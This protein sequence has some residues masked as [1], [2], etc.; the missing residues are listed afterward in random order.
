MPALISNP[1][2]TSLI[3]IDTYR[4]AISCYVVPGFFLPWL[5]QPQRKLERSR[6]HG[7]AVVRKPQQWGWTIA[8]IEQSFKYVISAK[9]QQQLLSPFSVRVLEVFQALHLM[10]LHFAGSFK[11]HFPIRPCLSAGGGG[12]QEMAKWPSAE[13]PRESFACSLTFIFLHF[14]CLFYI[15]L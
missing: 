14:S 11:T 1:P 7:T 3:S 6:R 9:S 15:F 2:S 8:D 13:C 12:W 5:V 10:P 4:F